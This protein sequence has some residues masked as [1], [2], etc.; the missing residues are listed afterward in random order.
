MN[1]E[2]YDLIASSLGL[3]LLISF[4]TQ[5]WLPFAQDRMRQDL[6]DLRDDLFD[7]SLSKNDKVAFGSL[8]F[9]KTRSDLNAM[10]RF[11]HKI[12]VVHSALVGIFTSH[13]QAEHRKIAEAFRS[14]LTEDERGYVAMVDKSQNRIIGRYLYHTSPVFW[15]LALVAIN[16]SILWS[17]IVLIFR[18]MHV[19]RTVYHKHFII[20]AVETFEYQSGQKLLLG[21]A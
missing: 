21:A 15:A 2:I 20:P 10:I 17:S 13:E 11:S 5:L 3:A 19:C 18:G 12:S 4:W 7:R 16:L 14:T 1:I 9:A 6:F 8:V